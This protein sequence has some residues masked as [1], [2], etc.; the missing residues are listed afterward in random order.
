MLS[1]LLLDPPFL[2]DGIFVF[3]VGF[4]AIGVLLELGV[5]VVVV[6]LKR[7]GKLNWAEAL[8]F[9]ASGSILVLVLILRMTNSL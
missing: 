6:K 9:W 2:S 1:A 8:V 5:A 3:L 7:R 4:L